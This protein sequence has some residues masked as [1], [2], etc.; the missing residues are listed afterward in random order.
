MDKEGGLSGNN[1]DGENPI[2]GTGL[3][4]EIPMTEV[5]TNHMNTSVMLPR[6]NT[7]GRGKVIV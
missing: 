7:Y 2:M 5:K 3:D 6:G 1:E 4:R